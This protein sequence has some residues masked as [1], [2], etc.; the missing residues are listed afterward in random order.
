MNVALMEWRICMYQGNIFLKGL[1]NQI[2]EKNLISKHRIS[3]L[4]LRNQIFEKKS[5]F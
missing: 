5:D 4:G 3:K 2:F 1:R